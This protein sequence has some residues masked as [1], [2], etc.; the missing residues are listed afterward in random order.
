MKKTAFDKHGLDVSRLG[1]GTVQFGVDYGFT[2]ALG[3]SAVDE[4]LDLCSERGVTYLDTARSYGDSEEKIGDYFSRRPKARFVVASKFARIEK[5]Q[6]ESVKDLAGALRDSLLA[7]GRALGRDADMTLLHQSDDFLISNPF[8]WEA[9]S[10]LKQE[11]LLNLFGVS[12]YEPKDIDTILNR[13]D[14]SM[15][16]VQ[17]PFNV[18]DR[19]FEAAGSRLRE[20]GISVVCRSAYLKGMIAVASSELPAW[21]AGLAPHKAELEAAARRSGFSAEEA[22]LLFCM[23]TGFIDTTIVGV[24]NAGQF[25]R[26]AD[27]A[28]RFGEADVL[29]GGLKGLEVSVPELVDPR[30]WAQYGF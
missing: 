6:A 11:G 8:F 25:K 4:I 29:V 9:L 28:D 21:A 2:K 26:N 27:I 5:E 23:K 24:D 14:A 15:D 22:A 19:R 12:F 3:Q 7:S 10:L 18:F 17:I 16:F 20:A 1:L 30:M 13:T